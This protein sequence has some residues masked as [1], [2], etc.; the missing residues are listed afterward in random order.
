MSSLPKPDQ[1]KAPPGDR[2]HDQAPVHDRRRAGVPGRAG[3]RG[4]L[5]CHAHGLG[6][7]RDPHACGRNFGSGR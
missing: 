3:F 1:V 2:N 7:F 5:A 4:L 6:A